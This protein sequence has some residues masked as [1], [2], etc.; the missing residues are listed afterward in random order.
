MINTIKTLEELLSFWEENKLTTKPQKS[1]LYLKLIELALSYGHYAL[2][3]DICK[4]ALIFYP[5][6]LKLKY[7]A[8]L[9]LA[10]GGSSKLAEEYVK[11]LL[12]QLKKKD[13][14][15][16]DVLSLAGRLAKDQYEKIPN[17]KKKKVKAAQA[18]EYYEKAFHLSGD[19]FPGINAASM[20]I[21]ANKK[22][23]ARTLAEMV[24]KNLSSPKNEYWEQATLGEAHTLL[25]NTDKAIEAYHKAFE[26][27]EKK[28]GNIASSKRQLRLLSQSISIEKE[29]SRTL[30][31]P[32]VVVFSGHM[33]DAP[34]RKSPRF[35]VELE[36]HVARKIEEELDTLN[37]N[38][39]YSSAACGSDIL[40]LEAMQK[41][42]GETHIVL[43]FAKEDFINISLKPGGASWV[44]RF[45]KVLAKATSV[46]FATDEGYLGD[47]I[48]FEYA[49]DIL[50]G[51]A[52]I[53]GKQLET[54]TVLLAV[55]DQKETQKN[56]KLGGTAATVKRWLAH[57]HNLKTIDL[58]LLRKNFPKN[59]K[60]HRQTKV[61]QAPQKETHISRHIK[62][63]LFADLVG[64]S[65]L[66]E[67]RAPSF[68]VGF[69]GK[70]AKLIEKS[71]IKPSFCNTWGD[72]LFIVFDE[73]TDAAQFA[74]ALRDMVNTTH[75]EKIGL[76]KE[77]SIRI[78]MHAGPVY[79]ARDPIIKHQ[80]FYG[81]HVNRAAR[82]EPVTASGAVYMSEQSASLLTTSGNKHFACDYLGNME[83]A[84]RFGSKNL[85]RLRRINETE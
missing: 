19:Y 3:F 27:S 61:Q 76:P 70:L 7:K 41:R 29:V 55:L 32:R 22:K 31:I 85:Y 2:G 10:R 62:A 14:L 38:F 53:R 17:G 33:I 66:G 11:D 1:I 81:T 52:L 71:S 73:V 18:A 25:G 30:A 64:F 20:S 63:M 40:F 67:D 34:E 56:T 83:L 49:S 15:L 36:K 23:H 42:G 26:F 79:G 77:T 39:G 47:D 59:K 35:P 69:L 37:A 68:F 21:L 4:K 12:S 72:G 51:M 54:E 78:G 65:K 9:A 44:K 6:D 5:K 82:I 75:W 13:P 80:N 24:L 74:L 16:P 57:H 60:I 84:K 28:W 46:S 58:S 43:P 48:L 8:A 45:D 50:E